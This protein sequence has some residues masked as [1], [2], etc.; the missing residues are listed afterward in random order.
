MSG[1]IKMTSYLLTMKLLIVDNKSLA[2]TCRET[3]IN[4]Y[5]DVETLN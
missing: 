3:D 5:V 4:G 2:Y 1:S